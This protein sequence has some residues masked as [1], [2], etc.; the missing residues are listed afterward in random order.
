MTSFPGEKYWQNMQALLAGGQLIIDRPRGRPHPRYADLIYPLDYGYLQ[1]TVSADG[2]GI[3]VWLGASGSRILTGILCTFDIVKQDAEVKLLAGCSSQEVE[4]I[5]HF[6]DSFI[7][8]L[9][10]PRP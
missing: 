8:S 3:D 4:T 5:L 1:G 6:S 2:Q 10:I 7:C 9:Y